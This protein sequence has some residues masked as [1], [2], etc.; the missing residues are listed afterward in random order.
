MLKPAQAVGKV[1]INVNASNID[2]LSMSG[3]KVYGPKGD[4]IL[5]SAFIDDDA[6]IGALYVR[7][8]PRVRLEPVQSGGGQERSVW[9]QPPLD[10]SAICRFRLT[11]LTALQRTAQ[12]HSAGTAGCRA[13]RR[14]RCG[15][16]RARGALHSTASIILIMLSFI[17]IILSVMGRSRQCSHCAVRLAAHQGAVRPADC[18]HFAGGLRSVVTSHGSCMRSCRW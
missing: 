5:S 1:P 17:V 13:G 11:Q 18:A 8:R 9:L 12:R 3:H 2:A 10:S 4:P 6:G 15:T 7:R 14:V 16:G